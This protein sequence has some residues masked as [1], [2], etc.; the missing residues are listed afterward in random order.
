MTQSVL[1]FLA[2]ASF[3]FGLIGID[4]YDERLRVA[5]WLYNDNGNWPDPRLPAGPDH[6]RVEDEFEPGA[7][8]AIGAGGSSPPSDLDEVEFYFQGWVFTKADPDPYP[9]TPHGH[10]HNQNLKWPKL[11]PYRGRVFKAKHQEDVMRR[12]SKKSMKKLWDD[13]RFRDFCR[14]HIMWY[15][16]QSPHH[17]FRV[18][19]PLRFPRW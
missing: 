5:L 18:R 19:N 9:S 2:E 10:W 15:M 4:E 7:G 16:E 1:T 14:A 11:D 6:D 13:G 12:L 17:A 8:N 3:R